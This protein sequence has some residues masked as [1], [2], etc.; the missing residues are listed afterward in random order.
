[1]SAEYYLAFFAKAM[2]RESEKEPAIS[3]APLIKKGTVSVSH[4]TSSHAEVCICGWLLY[5]AIS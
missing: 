2:F 4:L 3:P 5:A 1:M